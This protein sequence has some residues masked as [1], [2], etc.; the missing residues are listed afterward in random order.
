MPQTVADKTWSELLSLYDWHIRTVTIVQAQ[1]D[2]GAKVSED[3]DCGYAD[4]IGQVILDLGKA[5]GEAG[6]PYKYEAY[7]RVMEFTNGAAYVKKYPKPI[8]SYDDRKIQ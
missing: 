5:F 6:K 7:K 8:N 3:Y 1:I 2:R 4:A